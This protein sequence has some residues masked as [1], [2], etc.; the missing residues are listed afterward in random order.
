MD[1]N[2]PV[3]QRVSDKRALDRQLE[4]AGWALLLIMIGGL[5]LI[6]NVPE[7]VWLIGAGLIMVGVNI[8]RY[9]YGIRMR[10]FSSMLGA[11]ALVLG[12]ADLFGLGLPVLPALLVLIG[13]SILFSVFAPNVSRTQ[14][15]RSAGGL[16]T[17]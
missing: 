9:L 5:W 2:S 10:T 17:D 12:I 11:L 13:A 8:V 15:P 4:G 1:K 3:N 7:G 14:A 16:P 6:P